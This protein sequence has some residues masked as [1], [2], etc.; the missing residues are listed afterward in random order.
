LAVGTDPTLNAGMATL[1]PDTTY[2]DETK[3]GEAAKTTADAVAL[4]ALQAHQAEQVTLNQAL[5]AA[6]TNQGNILEE[7]RLSISS[8][9]SPAARLPPSGAPDHEEAEAPVDDLLRESYGFT[10]TESGGPCVPANTTSSREDALVDLLLRMHHPATASSPLPLST[11]ITTST[12]PVPLAALRD[13]VACYLYNAGHVPASMLSRPQGQQHH[14]DQPSI[15]NA[16]L[17]NARGLMPAYCPLLH[18]LKTQ[19]VEPAAHCSIT[20][21]LARAVRKGLWGCPTGVSVASMRPFARDTCRLSHP[22]GADAAL[23]EKTT[24]ST[25]KDTSHAVVG[26]AGAGGDPPPPTCRD[27]RSLQHVAINLELLLDLF[28]TLYPGSKADQPGA[29]ARRYT[30]AG[31]LESYLSVLK[32]R[33][34]AAAAGVLATPNAAKQLAEMIDLSVLTINQTL[35]LEAERLADLYLGTTSS[36]WLAT[37]GPDSLGEL[38]NVIRSGQSSLLLRLQTWSPST[39]PAPGGQ[40]LSDAACLRRWL[41]PPPQAQPRRMPLRS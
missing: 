5:L 11:G 13:D 19:Y 33:L 29:R 31:A 41:F 15:T 7:L 38:E 28:L 3:T 21:A 32:A 40:G 10:G 16:V 25:S 14:R 17:R 9:S 37:H 39:A 22:G 26:E 18:D 30:I 24:V 12:K 6:L 20:P 35:F 4:Q 27:P 1:F 23:N 36:F 8:S 34:D 2:G